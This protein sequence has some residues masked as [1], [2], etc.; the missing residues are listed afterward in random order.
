MVVRRF[1]EHVV[2]RQMTRYIA[3]LD[4]KLVNLVL[5]RDQARAFQKRLQAAG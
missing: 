4:E 2:E 1:R 5:A 3:S